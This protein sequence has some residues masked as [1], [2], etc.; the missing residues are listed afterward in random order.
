MSFLILTC[1]CL[2]VG[3]DVYKDD[4]VLAGTTAEPYGEGT[5]GETDPLLCVV[6]A[7][8]LG[9]IVKITV[10]SLSLSFV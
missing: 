5:C 2:S 9:I 1:F 3:I 4:G 6:F 8:Y 7:R 10:H